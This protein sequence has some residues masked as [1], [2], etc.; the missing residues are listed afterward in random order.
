MPISPE[1]DIHIKKINDCK[2]FNFAS[3]SNITTKEISN[4]LNKNI[5]YGEKLEEYSQI[6]IEY[7]KQH[8]MVQTSHYYIKHFYQDLLDNKISIHYNQGGV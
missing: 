3:S 7:L 4:I 1:P 2:M 5:I 6:D 8:I